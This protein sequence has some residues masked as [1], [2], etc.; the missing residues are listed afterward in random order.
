MEHSES[1][2]SLI[3]YEFLSFYEQNEKQY[4]SNHKKEFCHF[5]YKN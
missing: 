2:Y 4:E 5:L 1:V 3:S